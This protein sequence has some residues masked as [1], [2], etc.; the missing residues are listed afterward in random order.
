MI[1]LSV[2][3]SANNELQVSRVYL[4]GKNQKWYEER[5]HGQGKVFS[6]IFRTMVQRWKLYSVMLGI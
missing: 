3:W 5:E 2:L 4:N 6:L 1:A